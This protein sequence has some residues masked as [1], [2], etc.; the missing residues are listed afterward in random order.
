MSQPYV[1]QIIGVTFGWSVNAP[2]APVGWQLC[3]GS[4]LSVNDYQVL[5]TLLGTIY[6]GDGMNNFGVP[7][8]R[9]RVPIG[10]GQGTGLSPYPLGQKTGTEGVTLT[11]AQI[12]AH[13]H[14]LQVNVGATTGGN[15][16][17]SNVTYLATASPPTTG[18]IYGPAANLVALAPA[19][20]S[21]ASGGA[22]P[23]ENRQPFQAI[24]WIIA[25]Q[26]L[27]PNH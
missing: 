6:G 15:N 14:N 26:G 21:T 17:P 12:G 10:M 3:D 22:N 24:S 2:W 19:A 11:V 5:Y 18:K 1:G 8:L 4:L 20:I 9:G 13:T 25:T 16:V 23:H 7:D 27:F